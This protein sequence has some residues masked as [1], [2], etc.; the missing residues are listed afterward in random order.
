MACDF[1][2]TNFIQNIWRGGVDDPPRAANDI[3]AAPRGV[4]PVDDVL[5]LS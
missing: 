5:F 2:A 1:V 4:T 3:S